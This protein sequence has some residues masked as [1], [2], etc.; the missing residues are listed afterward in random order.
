MGAQDFEGVRESLGGQGSC[1]T[2]RGR[3]RHVGNGADSADAEFGGDFAED[4]VGFRMLRK[5]N[6][7]AVGTQDAGFFAGNGAD[8]GAKPLGVVERDVGDD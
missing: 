1:S 8:R 5:G 3:G 7:G 4:L 6:E 2:L